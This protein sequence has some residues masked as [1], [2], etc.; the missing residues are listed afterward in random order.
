MTAVALFQST[1]GIDPEANAG[2]LV[3]AVEEAAAGGA[4]M[5]FTPEMSG[6]LD[7]DAARAR[8][9]SAT[10]DEDRGAGRVPRG[11]GEAW[12]LAAPRLARRAGRGRQ[13]RQPRLRHRS[14]RR[15]PR[16][17]T[18]RSICSTSTCRPA[19]AGGSSNIYAAGRRRGARRWHAGRTAR[20]DHLLRPALS[21]PVRA[22]RRGR[23]R[24]IAVPAAFTV[25]TGMAHWHVLLRAR[26]IEAG[27]FVIAAAQVG[28]S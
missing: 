22:A 6:L 11:R 2:A 19:R 3:D 26:A 17:A 13:G 23:R 27:L 12:H 8:A 10:E 5:L 16:H 25:P 20:A 28:A 14:R 21:R 9:R 15:S 1:T 24:R 4:A 18:T 7:R